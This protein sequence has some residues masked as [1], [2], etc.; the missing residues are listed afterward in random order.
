MHDTD[1]NFLDDII[2]IN[3]QQNPYN[4]VR[5]KCGITLMV[6]PEVFSSCP[7]ILDHLN[8]DVSQCLR[9]LPIS[10]RPLVR[11]TRIWVN[12]TYCYGRC[13]QPEYVNHT[14]AHH[15]EGWLLW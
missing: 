4:K 2:L 12:H 8:S 9:I 13:S 11:R 1:D 5:L 7:S 14:T 6:R 3:N 10:V 15:H